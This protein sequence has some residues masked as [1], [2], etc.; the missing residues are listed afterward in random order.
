VLTTLL[1]DHTHKISQRGN[2]DIQFKTS[3]LPLPI[4]PEAQRAIFY[5]FQDV[6]SNIEKHAHAHKVHVSMEW[7]SLQ[8]KI[9][10][11]DNGRGFDP[12]SVVARKHFGLQIIQERNHPVRGR[13]DLTS[14][15][16]SGTRLVISVPY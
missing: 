11:S 12:R 3:G 4:S 16:N 6:L 15:E 10:V 13:I 5:A 2:I 1:L 9:T 14:N 7:E 8:L